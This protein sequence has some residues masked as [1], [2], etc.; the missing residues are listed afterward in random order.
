MIK[1][2][3]KHWVYE[4]CINRIFEAIENNFSSIYEEFKVGDRFK[5]IVYV[6][7]RVD[8]RETVML[9]DVIIRPSMRFDVEHPVVIIEQD[10]DES[11]VL[12]HKSGTIRPALHNFLFTEGVIDY[13]RDHD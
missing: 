10:R 8:K 13:T 5:R 4:A 6:N 7:P 11:F 1:V 2:F 9:Y 3:L 12:D